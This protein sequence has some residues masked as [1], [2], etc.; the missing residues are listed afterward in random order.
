[1]S[2]I[3]HPSIHVSETLNAVVDTCRSI[4]RNLY[5]APPE[6]KSM[7]RGD[8]L[9]ILTTVQFLHPQY[10]RAIEELKK[11][12]PG[13]I[14]LDLGQAL[15]EEIR[16]LLKHYLPAEVSFIRMCHDTKIGENIRTSLVAHPPEYVVNGLG[17]GVYWI[18]VQS[19]STDDE[20][21]VKGKARAHESSP[22]LCLHQSLQLL[23]MSPSTKQ[24]HRSS[25]LTTTLKSIFRHKHSVSW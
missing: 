4:E 5:D 12:H 7:E 19:L 16:L 6:V 14:C 11:I 23:L 20:S 10:A 13:M 25:G 2:Y 21:V 22:G 18:D 8:F 3:P 17:I 24:T 1:M 15:T 9:A